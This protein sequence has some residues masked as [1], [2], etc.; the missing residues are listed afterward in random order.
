LRAQLDHG[1]LDHAVLVV[2]DRGDELLKG[3]AVQT[4]AALDR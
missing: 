1:H 3:L 2:V 4:R